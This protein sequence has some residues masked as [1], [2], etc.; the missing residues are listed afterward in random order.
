MEKIIAKKLYDLFVVNR[1][2]LGI[3]DDK[4]IYRAKYFTV[5][6]DHIYKMLINKEAFGCFQQMYKSKY[7]KWICLDFDCRD[8]ES[9]NIN[10][11]Y[12]DCIK[13]VTDY[14]DKKEIFYSTEFSGRRGIHIWMLFDDFIGKDEAYNIVQAIKI[15]SKLEY[16]TLKYDLDEFPATP[17]FKGNKLGKQVKIPL[18]TH[19]LGTQSY[20]FDGKF[21]FVAREKNF[22]EEQ[23]KIIDDIKANQLSEV[24]NKLNV[25]G[26]RT[27][28]IYNKIKVTNEIDTSVEEIIEVLSETEVY[29]QIF[30]RF[31]NGTSITKDWFVILGTLGRIENNDDLL[32][33]IFKLSPNFSEEL[34]VRHI[35]EFRHKYYPATFRY[36]YNLYQLEKEDWIDEEQ[37]GLQFLLNRLGVENIVEDACINELTV[38]TDVGITK[39]KEL[40]YLFQNDEIPVISIYNDFINWTKYDNYAISEKIEKI[41]AGELLEITPNEYYKFIREERIDKSRTLITLNAHD[42]VLTT[43]LSVI[44]FYKLNAKFTS[45]SYNPNYISSDDIF[46]HWYSSW[47]NY[48]NEIN[49]YLESGIYDE[50]YVGVV[51]IKQFYDNVDLLGIYKNIENQLD[52][53]L[54]HI[55]KTLIKFNEKLMREINGSRIGVPQGPA[56]ARIICEYYMSLLIEEFLE[57]YGYSK[58]DVKIIRYVDDVVIFSKGNNNIELFNNFRKFLNRYGLKF[59]ENKSNIYDKIKNLSQE[60]KDQLLHKGDFQY[61]LRITDDSYLLSEDDSIEAIQKFINKK[62][63]FDINDVNYIFS[64][65]IQDKAKVT[66]LNKY[67]AD[68]FKS[69]LG[70]GSSYNKFYNYIYN[71]QEILRTCILKGYFLKI[72][73]N[74]IN[75]KSSI[76]N[77]YLNIRNQVISKYMY[78]LIADGFLIEIQ[79]NK[80]MDKKEKDIVNSILMYIGDK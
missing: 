22:L 6:E 74:S 3:M 29:N 50:H 45:F 64:N 17:S 35:N 42:R 14:L 72:P 61:D 28:K 7:L 26:K 73:I 70:R 39:N 25:R 55:I 79:N 54:K 21:Q 43:H 34:T 27:N 31:K 47:K 76:H 62:N 36:L 53:E 48:I 60:Q 57:F 11:L 66:Y 41:E 80:D 52:E 13:P 5:T 1:R 67:G 15:E 19:K 18:S 68:V 4:G 78:L 46:Y 24:Q 16:D 69:R 38:I 37:S 71:N 77:L 63:S 2:A 49:T 32:T 10:E 30:T 8:K 40:N 58:D 75:F 9:P 20:F 51:D 33:D 12:L 65:Q 23:N 59:N 56:Y 44:F